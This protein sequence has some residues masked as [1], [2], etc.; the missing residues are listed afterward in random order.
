MDP[1]RDLN[2]PQA[3]AVA[4]GDGALL[5]SAGAG[6]GKTR[7]LTRRIARLVD[8]GIA[9]LAEIMALTFTNRAAREMRRRVGALLGG[10]QSGDGWMAAEWIGTFH[11]LGLRILR[12]N[13]AGQ[14]TI[15]DAADQ[16]R[17][18]REVI[19]SNGLDPSYT[20]PQ[21]LCGFIEQWKN[22]AFYPH[23]VPKQQVDTTYAK[24]RAVELYEQYQ[25]R[26]RRANAMDFSDLLLESFTLLQKDE[27]LLEKYR[28]RFRHIL[29]DEYQDT[30]TLQ[31]MWLRLLVG[32][33]GNI[34]AV[35]D[36]DQC[37]YTW[38]GA[39][40]NNFL[41]FEKHFPGA[42][43]MRL[44][45]N[46]RSVGNIL[47]AASTLIAAN[48]A[49]V[50]KTLWTADGQG[51]KIRICR[52]FG[53][54]DEAMYVCG[55]IRRML[56]IGSSANR[57]AIL[58]RTS[59]LTRQFEE[60][61]RAAEV[62]YKV[63]GTVGF[64]GRLEVRDVLA[65]LRFAHNPNDELSL[66]RAVERPRCGI[67]AVTLDKAATMAATSGSSLFVALNKLTADGKIGGRAAAAVKNLTAIAADSNDDSLP[68]YELATSIV[69]RSGYL[70]HWRKVESLES[71]SRLENVQTLL[72]Q[73]KH[74]RT[75]GQFLERVSL[76]SGG[77]EE[78]QSEYIRIM[79]IH[80]AKGLE[81]ESVFLCGW[82]EGLLPH[83]RS[84]DGNQK[85][86]EEERR[87]AHVA[88]TRA[89]R[90]VVITHADN[91]FLW[92]KRQ[93]FAPS[94]FLREIPAANV[95]FADFR[96]G[97]RLSRRRD[98]DFNIGQKVSHPIF[99][100]GTVVDINERALI[101]DF[102]DQR[103]AIAESYVKAV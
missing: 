58:L 40:I 84:L 21:V 68:A 70:G 33:G 31:F 36:D 7:V 91:R 65:W 79:T 59:V 12:H 100:P 27:S 10:E 6:T 51:E 43:V 81:F 46:Y 80:A 97:V 23:R 18:A 61:L 41:Q 44:E 72:E 2:P 35:G 3:E 20:P 9:P 52:F 55:Q 82:D 16:L 86:L 53:D 69:K 25:Q 67:G 26:L 28:R 57:I 102:A 60:Y 66:R 75:L 4:F 99:G 30:N 54:K 39:E 50:K 93:E 103:R 74:C 37:I 14:V 48:S 96:R 89:K 15:L 8:E 13:S 38:R 94:R 73:A 22:A 85:G 87:L 90:N 11:A 83:Q 29:V 88:L 5:V 62:A 77:E 98:A 56:A 1:Y 32:S 78:E 19:K 95:L 49:R 63:V 101:I 64:Y 17:L 45:Q 71:E 24:G 42:K 34:C 92:G 76:V 47:A